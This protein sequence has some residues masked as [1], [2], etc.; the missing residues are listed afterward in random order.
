MFELPMKQF[1][2]M[3]IILIYVLNSAH[4]MIGNPLA[5][6][7]PEPVASMLDVEMASKRSKGFYAWYA[8]RFT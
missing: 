1:M 8:H 4:G 7:A 3:I 5:L 6:S 2:N